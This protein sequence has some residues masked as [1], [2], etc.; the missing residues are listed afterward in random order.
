MQICDKKKGKPEKCHVQMHSVS[1][2]KRNLEPVSIRQSICACAALLCLISYNAVAATS[3]HITNSG[4]YP[5]TQ[6]ASAHPQT[7]ATGG[8]PQT[9]ATGGR[10]QT[11]ATDDRTQTPATDDRTQTPAT[12]GCTQTP[13]TGGR[14][15]TPTVSDHTQ[16]PV[17]NDSDYT[18]TQATCDRTESSAD[19]EHTVKKRYLTRSKGEAMPFTKKLCRGTSIY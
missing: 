13:A 15:Q 6:A 19:T 3:A 11:S 2:C 14:P 12:G 10:P 4:A 9:P 16:T 18:Q 7:P 17:T 8:R 1:R 5:K